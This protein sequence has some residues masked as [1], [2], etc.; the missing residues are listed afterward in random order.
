MEEKLVILGSPP[1]GSIDRAATTFI[2]QIRLHLHRPDLPPHA[3]ARYVNPN[4]KPLIDPTTS[5]RRYH[6]QRMPHSHKT[7]ASVRY[8]YQWLFSPRHTNRTES[9]IG[10]RRRAK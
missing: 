8:P 2:D 10:P 7:L 6:R 1:L 4:R 5:L 9:T 3:A